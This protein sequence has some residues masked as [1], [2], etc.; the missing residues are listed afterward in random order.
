MVFDI[1]FFFMLTTFERFYIHDVTDHVEA[2]QDLLDIQTSF[3]TLRFDASDARN[4]K[5]LE[6]EITITGTYPSGHMT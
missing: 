5:S 3:Y 4:T 6:L 1:K 2:T